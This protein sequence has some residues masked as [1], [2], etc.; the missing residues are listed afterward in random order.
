[1]ISELNE[2]FKSDK[3]TEIVSKYDELQKSYQE[4]DYLIISQSKEN[5]KE[6]NKI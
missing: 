4:L 1:M 3:Y 2:L 6:R 5:V